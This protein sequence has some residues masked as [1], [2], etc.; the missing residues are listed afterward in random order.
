MATD[1]DRAA[2][3][4]ATQQQVDTDDALIEAVGI[5]LAD[6]VFNLEA[7]MRAA[8]FIIDSREQ[9]NL[10]EVTIRACIRSGADRE[11]TVR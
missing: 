8:G 5:G 1:T 7:A 4:A 6:D 10:G 2:E 11:I 9:T 3:D